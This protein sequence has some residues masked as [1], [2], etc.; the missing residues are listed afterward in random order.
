MLQYYNEI[1]VP[2]IFMSEK[3]MRSREMCGVGESC[4]QLLLHQL[5]RLLQLLV[6]GYLGFLDLQDLL[7]GDKGRGEGGGW[8]GKTIL[9]WWLVFQEKAGA[10]R[11]GRLLPR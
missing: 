3:E 2:I 4:L 5:T 1:Q 10:Y 7:G 6:I 8:G 11:C 9:V